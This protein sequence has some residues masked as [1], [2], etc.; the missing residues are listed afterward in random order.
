MGKADSCFVL[1]V[2]LTVALA[3]CV[4]SCDTLEA[5]YADLSTA[6]E[7]G[8]IDRGWIPEWLPRTAKAIDEV[9]DLDTNRRLLA[10]SFEKLE[11]DKFTRACS[12][13][14]RE[15]VVLPGWTPVRWWPADLR[16]GARTAGSYR[17]FSC[18]TGSVGS[19]ILKTT[20]VAVEDRTRRA[21]LWDAPG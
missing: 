9:H 2:G 14:F 13:V 16:Q 20:N 11:T 3:G 17:F 19:P 4:R 5:S 15:R 12:P 6:T 18:G 7:A 21:F 10:F 1:L 8:A